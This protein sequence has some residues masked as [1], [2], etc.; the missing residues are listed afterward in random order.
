MA[1]SKFTAPRNVAVAAAA[2]S[3]AVAKVKKPRKPRVSMKRPADWSNAKWI[4]DQ[5][6]QIGRAHV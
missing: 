5:T 2:P 1:P 3:A 4:A 6:R